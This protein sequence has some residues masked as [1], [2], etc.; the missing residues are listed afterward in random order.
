MRGESRRRRARIGVRAAASPPAPPA[1]ACRPEAPAPGIPSRALHHSA[2]DPRT[3]PACGA[4]SS[5]SPGKVTTSQPAVK[6]SPRWAR[7]RDRAAQRSTR[8]AAAEVL[9]QRHAAPVRER[10]QLGERGLGGE[11][12][13]AKVAAMDPQNG[14]G[15][16]ML[17]ERPDVVARGACGWWCR[18]RAAWRRSSPGSR[19]CG[20]SRRSRPAR[21]ARRSPRA[22]RRSRDSTSSSAAAPL[23]HHQR[24]FGAGESLEPALDSGPALAAPAAWRGRTRGWSSRAPTRSRAWRAASA[25]GARPR[26]VWRTTPVAFNTRRSSGR[27]SARARAATRDTSSSTGA[28]A[29]PCLRRSR[30][31]ASSA[32][33]ASTSKARGTP[34]TAW[35]SP[36]CWSRVSTAGMDLNWAL[37]EGTVLHCSRA[38]RFDW[39][40]GQLGAD[41]R[42]R[43]G[44]A[45][46]LAPAQVGSELDRLSSRGHR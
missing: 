12:C 19:G 15:V 34:F 31:S 39:P 36:G 11:A 3:S 22:P 35:A 16:A 1:S 2:C 5:L 4:P 21:R 10:R 7:A 40:R 25:S 33:A 45:S 6:L 46:Q 8:R 29:L 14:A 38:A 37:F 30:A 41:P 27:C 24:R 18:P 23:L 32:R 20:R 43:Q 17:L 9:D 26:L 28:G 44:S 13:D 42:V